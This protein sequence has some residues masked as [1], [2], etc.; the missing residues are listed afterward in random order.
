MRALSR[1]PACPEVSTVSFKASFGARWLTTP[2]S[3]S[4]SPRPCDDSGS[5]S[6][7][8][9]RY[10]DI[11]HT[12]LMLV[13]CPTVYA[14]RISAL[15]FPPLLATFLTALLA[16]PTLQYAHSQGLWNTQR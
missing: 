11:V 4:G 9:V 2:R 7:I 5:V 8:S 10:T 15:D 14:R 12:S 1:S 3:C 13:A 6:L 16:A